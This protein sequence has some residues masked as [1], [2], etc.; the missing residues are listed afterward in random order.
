MD[1][2]LCEPILKRGEKVYIFTRDIDMTG[3]ATRCLHSAKHTLKELDVD[4]DITACDGEWALLE[5]EEGIYALSGFSA[6]ERLSL[7]GTFPTWHIHQPLPNTLTHL[8]LAI[9]GVKQDT[10]SEYRPDAPRFKEILATLPHL[11]ELTLIN[12]LPTAPQDFEAADVVFIPFP[13][14]FTISQLQRFTLKCDCVY[15]LRNDYPYFWR[16]FKVPHTAVVKV[17][18]ALGKSLYSAKCLL[19]ITRMDKVAGQLP[20]EMTLSRFTISVRHTESAEDDW[21]RRVGNIETY[22][23]H[24]S[25]TD[26]PWQFHEDNWDVDATHGSRHIRDG[27]TEI[28]WYI[29][30]LPLSSLRAV[31]L[32]VSIFSVNLNPDYWTST[33]ATAKDVRRLSLSYPES[34]DVLIELSRIEDN[35]QSPRLFPQLDTL[36]FHE[37]VI[38]APRNIDYLLR[39]SLE[40]QL[41]D[42][43]ATRAKCG[44]PIKR[45]LVSKKIAS[46]EIWAHVDR[47]ITSISCF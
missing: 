13:E 36:I 10:D 6:L 38:H 20:L 22:W 43:L 46:W 12:F 33:F 17:D 3:I 25:T 9:D 19:P 2:W 29:S 11:E 44:A 7:R 32:A 21:T 41:L 42:V 35:S 27:D 24:A 34:S 4:L 14:P 5:P 26:N 40:L 18:I 39:S 31:N 1:R 16:N 47:T 23:K 30:A 37:D 45:I 8:C 28:T 15:P